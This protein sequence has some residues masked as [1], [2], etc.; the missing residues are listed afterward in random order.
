MSDFLL[1]FFWGEIEAKRYSC[2]IDPRIFETKEL[3]E[4][5]NSMGEVCTTSILQRSEALIRIG[6][7]IENVT[8]AIN[9]HLSD[10]HQVFPGAQDYLNSFASHM[11]AES[12]EFRKSESVIVYDSAERNRRAARAERARFGRKRWAKDVTG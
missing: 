6:N 9:K 4:V 1:V 7:E 11:V 8:S 12:L 3:E 10:E 5:I 2:P